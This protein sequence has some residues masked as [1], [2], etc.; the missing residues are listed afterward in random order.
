MEN[1][2]KGNGGRAPIRRSEDV[3]PSPGRG[4]TMV[5][6]QIQMGICK[7]EAERRISMEASE[8]WF[9]AM[10]EKLIKEKTGEPNSEDWIDKEDFAKKA[11]LLYIQ[12]WISRSSIEEHLEIASDETEGR[13]DRK[14]NVLEYQ[15]APKTFGGSEYIAW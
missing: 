5:K 7:L 10:Q 9:H 3:S 8:E 4:D 6:M 11:V 13:K 12:S 1:K 2:G 14:P 15:G